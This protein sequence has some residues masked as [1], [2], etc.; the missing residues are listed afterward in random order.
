MA[1][2]K[3][4]NKGSV[5]VEREYRASVA[6]FGNEFN[7]LVRA[8]K[9][10]LLRGLPRRLAEGILRMRQGRVEMQPG[11]DGE[12]GK[13]SVFGSGEIKNKEEEQLSLF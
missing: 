4:V 1:E 10:E 3:G 9:D 12:Y 13:I 11:F 6:R 2:A 8:S 5:A 7:V